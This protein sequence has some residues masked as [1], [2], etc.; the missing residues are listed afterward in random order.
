MQKVLKGHM[1]QYAPTD[2]HYE[3]TVDERTGKVKRTK[4]RQTTIELIGQRKVP[5]GLSK[6]DARGLKKIRRRAHRLDEG[7]S[8]CGMRVGYTFFIGIS[9]TLDLA[10]N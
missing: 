9:A 3:E 8:F 6:R 1:A 7:M 10:L 5:D 4:V 2:P